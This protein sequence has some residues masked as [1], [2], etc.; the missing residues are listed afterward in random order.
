M[1]SYHRIGRQ[2]KVEPTIATL[3]GVGEGRDDRRG[4]M[5]IAM[6]DIDWERIAAAIGL[7]IVLELVAYRLCFLLEIHEPYRSIIIAPSGI[8]TVIAFYRTRKHKRR[9]G[10]PIED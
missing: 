8:A 3:A 1:N 9:D 7:A 10:V 2:A 6:N 5:E 4:R